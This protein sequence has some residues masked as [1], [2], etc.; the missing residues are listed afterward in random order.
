MLRCGV[1][2]IAS[3]LLASCGGAE[4]S[5]TNVE[6]TV[7]TNVSDAKASIG[8]SPPTIS[9]ATTF[10]TAPSREDGTIDYVEAIDAARKNKTTPENNA[11][12]LI[13]QAHGPSGLPSGMGDA[14]LKKLGITSLGDGPFFIGMAAFFESRKDDVDLKEIVKSIEDKRESEIKSF[15][16]QRRDA[17][18]IAD[19]SLW[20]SSQ[21][22]WVTKDYPLIA[23]WLAE[24]REP[25]DILLEAT[26]RK[27]FYVPRIHIKGA[28]EP[29]SLSTDTA[30]AN[31]RFDQI[32][33]F[34]CSVALWQAHEE[35]N[36]TPWDYLM[37]AQRLAALLEQ[38]RHTTGIMGGHHVRMIADDGVIAFLTSA[39]LTNDELTQFEKSYRNVQ[40]TRSILNAVDLDERVFALAGVMEVYRDAP[41]RRH[42]KPHLKTFYQYADVDAV[43]RRVNRH[44]DSKLPILRDQDYQSFKKKSDTF[45]RRIDTVLK[46]VRFNGQDVDAWFSFPENATEEAKRQRVTQAFGDSLTTVTT[47]IHLPQSH[48]LIRM[49]RELILV[50][51]GLERYRLEHGRYPDRITD[52]VPLHVKLIP[53]DLFS[54]QRDPVRYK[55]TK[56]GYVLY[57]VGPNGKDDGASPSIDDGDDISVVVPVLVED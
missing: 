49:R 9:K 46:A 33:R 1:L 54:K 57:S 52:A 11:F 3:L 37:A 44:F 21:Q 12:K 26:K 2:S 40:S 8:F 38:Q 19:D 17:A 32:A 22:P 34:F 31:L 24:N 6:L 45:R 51:F 53:T 41:N 42:L 5:D 27:N 39:K 16:F 14:I 13:I 30:I 35:D 4:P 47:P 15:F 29:T 23:G 36:D 10:L 50:A 56:D 55:R 18:A 28:S 7:D 48:F 25:F 43:L 20:K